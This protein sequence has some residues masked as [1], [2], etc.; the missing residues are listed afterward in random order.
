MTEALIH[1]LHHSIIDSLKMLP[2]LYVAFLLMELIEHHAADKLT[3]ILVKGAHS[4][5]SGTV[6]GSLLG[7]IPQCGFSVAASN[8][9]SSRVI[10][11]G[12]LMAVFV[13]TSDEAIP[14][15]LAHPDS[16]V[17]IWNLIGTKLL[18]AVMAGILFN[19]LLPET[20]NPHFEEVCTHCGCGKHGPWISSL[21]HTIEIFIFIFIVNYIMTFVFEIAGEDSV[22]AFFD[23]LGFFQPFLAALVGL[24]PNC[25]SSVIIT[26]LF[27][28][29]TIPFGTAVGG[30]CTGAGLGLAVLFRSNKNM[31][32]NFIFLGYLYAVGVVSGLLLNLV[33]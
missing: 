7:C 13:S 19:I 23:G 10:S 33:F 30:L 28:E 18:V 20:E 4:N 14:I 9:Y 31:K 12:T 8:L 25:A 29:G 21:K 32:E 15:M 6:T 3:S 2:F 5:V 17:A 16:S 27:L 1:S 26:E 22:K 11:A 24:I